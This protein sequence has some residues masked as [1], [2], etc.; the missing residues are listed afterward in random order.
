MLPAVP[1]KAD[2][3]QRMDTWDYVL[4]VG[5]VFVLIFTI[6]M[7]VLLVREW[8]RRRRDKQEPPEPSDK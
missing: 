1:L 6:V 8:I 2:G 3:D 5:S 7:D 4:T